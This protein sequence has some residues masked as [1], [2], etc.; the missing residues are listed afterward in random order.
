MEKLGH[1][2]KDVVRYWEVVEGNGHE[3]DP[4][5]LK[6]MMHFIKTGVVANSV[7]KLS[8]EVITS[9]AAEKIMSYEPEI[10][11]DSQPLTY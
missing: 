2:V 7:T 3:L 1:E 11:S 5:Y 4:R 8:S 6:F 9:E 10:W